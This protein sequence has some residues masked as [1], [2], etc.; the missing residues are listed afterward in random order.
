MPRTVV[1]VNNLSR[2]AQSAE[3]SFSRFEGA[4]PTELIGRASFP[5]VAQ[6]AYPMTLGPYG[7]YWLEIERG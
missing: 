5:T 1:C 4:T 2:F 3:V 7:S 6:A